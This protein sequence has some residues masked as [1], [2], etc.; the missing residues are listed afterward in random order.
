[1]T[2]GDDPKVHAS[3]NA[4]KADPFE[5]ELAAFTAAVGLVFSVIL[6]FVHIKA[7]AAPSATS[8]CT[9]GARLDCISVAL[10]RWSVIAGIPVPVWGIAGFLAL[11][12][13][14][15]WRARAFLWLSAFAAFA[16]LV[17]LATELSSIRSVCLLCEG[18]HAAAFTLFGLA[19]VG[20]KS[21]VRTEPMTLV[22]LFTVPVGILLETYFLATPYWA[23]FEAQHGVRLPHGKDEAGH[24]W[25]GAEAPQIVAHEYVDYSC[26]HCAV[27]ASNVRSL[28]A[29]HASRLRV[30]R[31][32]Y[33]HMRC[34]YANDAPY[35]EFVR[36]AAC[37][38]EQGKFWEMDA[39][40]FQHAPGKSHLDYGD[41][42]RSLGLDGAQFHA[43]LRSQKTFSRVDAEYRDASRA[44]ILGTPA[45]IIDGKQYAG[46]AA[47]EE[48]EKRL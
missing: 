19:W 22:H 1:M 12:L 41:A 34:P 45:Y 39:W 29:K 20:R 38:D 37:A 10:S 42:I 2:E 44:R 23:F 46:G 13:T 5:R 31:H 18:A 3:P 25:I 48:L 17:L 28:L 30:V 16:S 9:V 24:P 7:F 8:F 4:A 43:C 27:V 40:L 15:W 33:A 6:E 26:P 21:L 36:A 35:C 47:I 11:G 14:A 32:Q